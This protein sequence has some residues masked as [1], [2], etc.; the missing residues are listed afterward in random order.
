MLEPRSFTAEDVVEIHTHG[1]G[2]C[3]RRVLDALLT[4]GARLARPGEFTLRAFLNG[5]LDLTQVNTS[6]PRRGANDPGRAVLACGAMW[7]S[8]R[9]ALESARR[10]RSTTAMCMSRRR[11]HHREAAIRSCLF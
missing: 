7:A 4:A 11:M 3:A 2:V 9:R 1:G 6:A 10:A 5:R 8:G